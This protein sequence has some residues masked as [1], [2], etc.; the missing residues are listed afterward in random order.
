MQRNQGFTIIELMAVV[1]IV[2]IL[3]VL[4]LSAYT[5]YTIRAKVSEGMNFASEAKTSVSEYFY[6][7]GRMPASNGSAGLVDP[8]TYNQFEFLESL[9]IRTTPTAGSIAITFSLPG[10][11]ADGK[12]LWLVPRTE[13][14]LIYWNCYPPER[15]GIGRNQA[16]PN[17]RG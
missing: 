10:T 1:S 6:S 17:C 16:P 4:A 14:R 3:A 8:N 9:E 13:D 5:D 15:N 11:N 12:E 7:V 2:S